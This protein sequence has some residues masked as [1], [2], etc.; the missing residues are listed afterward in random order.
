[1]TA[2]CPYLSATAREKAVPITLVT[3]DHLTAWQKS[4]S[5]AQSRWA[6]DNDFTAAAG[7]ILTLA[8]ADGSL[9][10][11]ALGMGTHHDKKDIWVLATLAQSLPK[12]YYRLVSEHDEKLAALGWAMAQYKF[13]RYLDKKNDRAAVLMVSTEDLQRQVTTLFHGLTLVR[14]LVNTPTCDMGPSHLSAAMQALAASYGATFHETVGDALLE[15]GY[16]TIHAVG[17][18]AAN[19]PRLLDMS[20]GRPDAPKLTLVGKGVCFDTGGLDLKPSSGMRIMKKDMGGAAHS[21]GLARMIMDSGLDVRLRVLIPAVENNISADAFRPGDIITTYKGT[22][23]EIDNTDAE[24]RL[25]LCDALTLGS[26]EDPDLMLDFATLTGAARVAMGSDIVPFFT[27]GDDIAGALT[28][29]SA[30]ESDP[31]WRMPLY[32]P[33]ESDLKSKCADMSN[34]GSGPYGGAIIA[35]LYL[36]HFVTK[37]EKWVHFDVFAWNLN[38]RPGRPQGGEAMALRAVLAYLTK[39]YGK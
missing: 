37:P 16:N 22:T 20:W 1:M 7:Q 35:A 14:D 27:D 34:M 5:P 25:V 21:L 3:R 30:E 12:G 28:D 17:R 33:Y 38:N 24:G 4:L 31:I 39:R 19:A 15:K 11:V 36:K 26:E 2:P 10:A 9:E 18:A 29:Q 6:D 8:A 32:A 13:D 23:V